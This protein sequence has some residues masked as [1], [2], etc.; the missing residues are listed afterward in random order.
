MARRSILSSVARPL[1]QPETAQPAQAPAPSQGSVARP[2]RVGKLHVG[3]YFDPRDPTVMAF[4]KLT[5]ELRRS[6]QSLLHEAMA[7]F[8]AKTEAAKAFGKDR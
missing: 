1:P 7:D 5:V 8:V 6:Q 2:S 3:G 4:Q